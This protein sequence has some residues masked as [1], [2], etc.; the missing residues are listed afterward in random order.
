MERA[1]ARRRWPRARGGVVLTGP[2]RDRP[3]ASRLGLEVASWLGAAAALLPQEWA[4]KA[5]Q[6]C[7]Q[8]ARDGTRL[9]S[10]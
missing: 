9:V 10:G 3:E 7:L 4:A 5:P 1:E 2:G 8:I 6:D